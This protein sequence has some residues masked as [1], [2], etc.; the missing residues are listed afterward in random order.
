MGVG[1][2]RHDGSSST[3]WLM[4][5]TEKGK[6]TGRGTVDEVLVAQHAHTRTTAAADG[7]LAGRSSACWGEAGARTDAWRAVSP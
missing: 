3:A 6:K 5:H 2:K 7:S 4:V 1:K